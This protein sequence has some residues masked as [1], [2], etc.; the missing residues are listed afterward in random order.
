LSA[1]RAF[2]RSNTHFRMELEENASGSR[3]FFFATR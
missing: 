2:E 3:H 1:M